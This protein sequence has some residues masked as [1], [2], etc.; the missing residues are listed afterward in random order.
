MNRFWR[1]HV[2]MSNLDPPVGSE[3]AGTRPVLVISEDDYNRV[4]P[5]VTVLPITSKKPERRL[6]ADEVLVEAGNAGLRLDSIVLVHH[7]RTISKRR[8]WAF[9]GVLD[10]EEKQR[11]I[12]NTIAEHL[13]LW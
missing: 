9:V 5:L 2:F 8:L 1:W 11:E 12:I 7:I 13:E 4:M 10:D 6:Y 3:Q